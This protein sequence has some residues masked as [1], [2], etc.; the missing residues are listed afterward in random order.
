MLI[1]RD[2]TRYMPESLELEDGVRFR[3][4]IRIDEDGRSSKGMQSPDFGCQ[5][6]SSPENQIESHVE[7]VAKSGS[8]ILGP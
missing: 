5:P 6:P 3:I 7:D 2:P 8:E 4:T 1:L